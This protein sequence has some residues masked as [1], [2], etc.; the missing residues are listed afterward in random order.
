[1]EHLV[2]LQAQAPAPPYFGLWTRLHGFHHVHLSDLIARRRV[3]RLALMRS[4]IHL[5]TAR[6]ALRLR[7]V[8][9]PVIVRGAHGSYGRRL[10]GL[11]L[12]A[13][14]AAARALVEEHPRTYSDIGATLATRWPERDPAALA[15]AARALVPL[16]QVP[17]RGL[18]GVPGQAAH[19]TLE[20]WLGRR[21]AGRVAPSRLVRRYLAAFGPASVRD[22]QAWS[23]LTRL[24]DVFERLRS[25]LRVFRAESGEELF[26]LPDAP[27]PAADADAAPRFLPEFDN[28][29][30]AYVDRSR[31]IDTRWR[32]AVFNGGMIR[33]TVAIDGFVHGTWALRR[34]GRTMTLSIDLF[35]PL[36][37][38]ARAAMMQEGDRLLAFAVPDGM[39]R[40][41]AVRVAGRSTR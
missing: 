8:V 16:V 10:A 11:D 31:M 35:A 13:L 37:A 19:T 7:P 26:D 40:D 1:M 27:R 22:A 41:I 29:L 15:S 36:R 25:A 33:S 34:R 20:A 30:L 5:V 23:G 2:G 28:V 39:R 6:D 32:E 4:T 12:D 21:P 38:E 9:Q 14:A 24:R 3:V 17:P 18:W